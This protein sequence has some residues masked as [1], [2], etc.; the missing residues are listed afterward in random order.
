MRASA[1]SSSLL[2]VE[3]PPTETGNESLY[4]RDGYAWSKQQADALRRQD[5]EAIDWDNVIEEIEAV[6][7]AERG[8]WVG[9][10]ASALMYLLIVEHW[11]TTDRADAR[12]WRKE[13][14]ASRLGIARTIRANPGLQGEYAEMLAEAWADGRARAVERLA[15]YAARAEGIDD[16]ERFRRA[17]ETQLPEECPYLVEHVAAY[18]PK[19]VKAP[20]DEVWP[21]GVAKV[22]DR[23][24]G[25]HYEIL[26]EGP[27]DLT[28]AVRT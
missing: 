8:N 17:F 27:G 3:P 13:I 26:R 2:S 16:D 4:A 22:F 12:G 18:D 1:M 23:L 7:R 21:P 5:L 6:G 11:K 9:H 24:L 28:S 15:E 20:R 10:C 19:R 25:T 14:R